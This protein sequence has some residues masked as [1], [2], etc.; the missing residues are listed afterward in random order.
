MGRAASRWPRCR[1]RQPICFDFSQA[2]GRLFQFSRALKMSAHDF[3]SSCFKSTGTSDPHQGDLTAATNWLHADVAVRLPGQTEELAGCQTLLMQ[4]APP[5]SPGR[6]PPRTSP[7]C[8]LAGVRERRDPRGRPKALG[9]QP[10]TP[11]H[12]EKR[13]RCPVPTRKRKPGQE[14]ALKAEGR[15]WIRRGR[16]VLRAWRGSG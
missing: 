13:S 9:R 2:V 16:S 6:P 5:R 12:G 3:N 11:R 10:V 14:R 15:H 8:R 1:R 7:G 4:D